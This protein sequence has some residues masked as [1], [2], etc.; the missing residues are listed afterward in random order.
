ML[1][2]YLLLTL[3]VSL[4][5]ATVE[6]QISASSTTKVCLQEVE[7]GHIKSISEVHVV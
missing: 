7:I 6:R 3:L 2:F 5:I 1:L 4:V